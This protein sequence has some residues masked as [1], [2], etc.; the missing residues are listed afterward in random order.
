VS[1]LKLEIGTGLM[2][3]HRGRSCLAR[4]IVPD[5]LESAAGFGGL[6]Y[7]CIHRL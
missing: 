1:L 3:G 2:T 6:G 5:Y 7:R 4:D